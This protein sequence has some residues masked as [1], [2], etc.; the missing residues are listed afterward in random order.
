MS[1]LVQVPATLVGGLLA[2]GVFL[3]LLG[4]ASRQARRRSGGRWGG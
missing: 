4:L 2:L 1:A 3:T